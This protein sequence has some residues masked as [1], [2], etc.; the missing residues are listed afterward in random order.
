[1]K[2]IVM[3][4]G[5]IFTAI[6]VNVSAEFIADMIDNN[7]TS[8]EFVYG[9]P[10]YYINGVP[11]VFN[12]SNA[13]TN[14]VEYGTKESDFFEYLDYVITDDYYLARE[15]S[16]EGAIA[17][18]WPTNTLMIY[19]KEFNLIKEEDFGGGVFVLDMGYNN[20][21]FYCKYGEKYII[22]K[23]ENG[24][25]I[26]ERVYDNKKP[27]RPVKSRI[28]TVISTDMQTWTESDYDIPRT[29]SVTNM[30]AN[31][32]AV[33]RGELLPVV[34][35][36]NKEHKY[37]DKSIGWRGVFG[38]WFA[39]YTRSGWR[40]SQIYLSNDNVY[41]V[42]IGLSEKAKSMIIVNKDTTPFSAIY[43]YNDNILIR[44]TN[45]QY[46]LGLPKQEVYNALDEMKSAPYVQYAG[47]IL[48]FEE[49]PAMEDDR[50][51]VPMRFLFE[52]M[53]AEVD[54]NN[55]TQTATATLANQAVAFSIDDTEAEVNSAPVT[56]DVPAR[57]VNGKT[58]VPIRF[59]SENLGYTVSWD[60]ENR[61]ATIE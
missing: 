27:E 9:G 52:Q 21:T 58:M 19:D 15:S 34:Y 23:D 30:V 51:L 38:D 48:G 17:A 32:S 1:M 13:N 40:V 28:I 33:T 12:K 18:Y 55:D 31:K 35:E 29:N 39:A 3:L 11:Y 41:F 7:N 8:S 6:T 42:K 5:I 20:G 47:N 22:K 37:Y 4:I 49:P 36:D 60:Q 56:M 45:T 46:T 16:K 54:W 26:K 43:E 61:I 44:I 59:L 50:I 2:R 10:I 14:P 57:L 24:N 53:G 25:E